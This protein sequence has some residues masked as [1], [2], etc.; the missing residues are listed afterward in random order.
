MTPLR[1]N[2]RAISTVLTTIIILVASVVLGSGVVVYGTS[3]FQGGTQQEAISVQGVQ[4]WVNGTDAN[5]IA[6]GAAAVRNSGDKILSVDKIEVR[7][8]NVPFSQWYVD[9]D[10]DRVTVDNFQAQFVSEGTDSN[11]D[12]KDSTSV[13]TCSPAVELSIDLDGATTGKPTLCLAVQTGPVGLN[14]GDRMVIYFQ[15]PDGTL[16][17]LD[18]GAT[19][20]LNIFAGKTG[21]PQSVTIGNT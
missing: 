6:W 11:G 1:N 19:S 9:T 3:L 7:G 2:R 4:L 14:P 12:M 20:S 8:T 16:S 21:A 5:G 15:L 13:D 10:P 17:S 18:A